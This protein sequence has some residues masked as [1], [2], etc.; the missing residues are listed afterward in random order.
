MTNKQIL[1]KYIPIAEF[2]SII[3][4]D[5]CEVVLHDVTSPDNSI[6]FIK[7]GKLSGRSIGG[8]ITDMVLN[9]VQ[10]KSY[11][12]KNFVCNYKAVGN[13]KTFRSAS[14]FIK[15][16]L[17]EIIGVICVNIDIEPYEKMKEILDKLSFI[18]DDMKKDFKKD[19][20]T[21]E[22]LY[23]N[24]NELLYSMIQETLSKASVELKRMDSDEKINIVKKLF[25][26]G[27]FSLKGAVPEVAKALQVS[28]PTIYRYLNK[29]K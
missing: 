25:D 2:I 10:N 29:M 26:K 27:A 8:P 16:D 1:K 5:N 23:S 22:K 12:K 28:E 3:L 15:N 18:S 19:I 11:K 7:N 14:Y 4:G 13:F 9:I 24:V 20:K 21:K 17:H 6:I